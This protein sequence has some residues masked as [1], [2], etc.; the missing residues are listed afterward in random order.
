MSGVIPGPIML[1][2][3]TTNKVVLFSDESLFTLFHSDRGA[4]YV[5]TVV[6][7]NMTDSVPQVWW[8]WLES[9]HKGGQIW[10]YFCWRFIGYCRVK[11][12]WFRMDLESF[13][14][15]YCFSSAAEHGFPVMA[16]KIIAIESYRAQLAQIEPPCPPKTRQ[17]A[18]R[19]ALRPDLE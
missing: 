14:S 13:Q 11:I 16:V 4:K 7:N 1:V 6:L 8:F 5:L 19:T 2:G 3:L 18:T 17:I 12:S 10:G 9:C 15:I